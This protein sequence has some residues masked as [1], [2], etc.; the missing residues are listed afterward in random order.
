MSKKQAKSFDVIVI[1]AGPAG[2]S[3]AIRCAQLG[4]KTACIDNWHDEEGQSSLGG[5]YLNAGCVA[6]IALLES[7][8]IYQSINHNLKEHGIQAE[9]V[10]VD[11]ALMMQRKN[12]I[13]DALSR[14]IA[15]SFAH[16]KIDCIQAEAKL[17]NERRVEI[18][19]TDH[20]AVS[21]IEAKHIVLATG[22]SPVD[23]SCAPIDNEFIIDTA[24]ALNLDAV[25]KRLAIIGAGI[26]GLE[27]AG[28]WNRL[29]AETI[30]LEAQESFL[31]LADQQIA[32]EA[33]RIYTEQGL[34]LR[35]GARVISA[36]KGSK[37][38]TVEYQDSEGTH[39]LR[40]DK[41][42]VASGRKPN[43][44]NLAAAEAN[45]L[46]DEN[47]YVH[48]DENCRT[49]LPGVYAI[50]DLTLLGPMI[51]HKG[52]EEGLFVAEQIA[53]L[54]N[55]VNYDL[56]P[57]VVFTDPEIAWVGQTEQALRAMGEPIKIGT[58]PLKATARAQ[59]MGQTEGMVKII[60]HAETDALLGIHIIGTQASEMIAE[61]VLAMEFSASSEDL[62]RTIHA[63][64][65]LAKALHGAALT[66][67]NKK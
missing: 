30:L 43:T 60:A 63:H 31:G 67:K 33:Y 16:C 66:L 8:K 19:P 45:L 25:P 65:T 49:T 56:L 4:L 48:V 40:V 44:E 35:L 61:A 38:V 12:N 37:K 7:A 59:A 32:R 26:I 41:L 9:A 55:P 1:G 6:S 50:G 24:M 58:F 42:I 57:S 34:E 39:A 3:S 52:I 64:P 21:I 53:G 17:L 47:G 10:S 5:T 13:I 29:G 28:I 20:S 54:H 62:A 15:D 27:L 18:T 2:Y 36:K 14:Q 23:L 51:A 22:S 11:I 46:L